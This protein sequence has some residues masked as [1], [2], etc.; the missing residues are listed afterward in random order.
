MDL[1]LESGKAYRNRN[2]ERISIC[3][4]LGRLLDVGG[5]R[6][7][8]CGSCYLCEEMPC[9]GAGDK[10]HGYDLVAPWPDAPPGYEDTGEFRK[11]VVGEFHVS[12]YGNLV[13]ADGGVS[14]A[15]AGPFGCG[16][17]RHIMRKIQPPKVASQ[18]KL[19][20]RTD[21]VTEGILSRHPDLV[22]R[23]PALAEDEIFGR[24]TVLNE[25]RARGNAPPGTHER[26][27]AAELIRAAEAI[28]QDAWARRWTERHGN[29]PFPW[30]ER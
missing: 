5:R 30:L 8:G 10:C 11:P 6:Y 9:D 27:R 26:A 1:K 14:A 19:K 23:A 7:F 13:Q 16:S 24:V 17:K 15:P 12:S 20:T 3:L 21:P 22:L 29:N 4:S 2:G 28:E 25:A 18:P